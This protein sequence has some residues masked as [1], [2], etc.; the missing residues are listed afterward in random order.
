MVFCGGGEKE[1]EV[2]VLNKTF[3]Y[4]IRDLRRPEGRDGKDERGFL[5]VKEEP[6]TEIHT[7]VGAFFLRRVFILR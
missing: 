5:F 4:F 7:E 6:S 3:A 2:E 1:L